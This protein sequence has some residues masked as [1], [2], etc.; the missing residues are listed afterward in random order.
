MAE[1]IREGVCRTERQATFYLEAGPVEGPLMIFVHGWP[2]MG[3][4]WRHQMIAFASLGF[5]TVAP[6]V[7]GFGR[8]AIPSDPRQL[9]VEEAVGDLLELLGHLGRDQAIWVGHDSGAAVVWGL[10]SHHPQAC[11]AVANLCVPYLPDGF[12]LEVCSALVDRG[13]YPEPEYP[14]GQWA[15]WNYNAEHLDEAAKALDSDVEAS[16][17]ICFRKG[18]SDVYAAPTLTATM[19]AP[20]GWWP[21]VEYGRHMPIDSEIFSPEEYAAF[22]TAYKMTGFAPGLNYYK[23]NDL[24]ADYAHRAVNEG[25][26]SMPVLFI[27]ASYDPSCQTT[28]SDLA[29]PMRAA[30]ANLV[31]MMVDAGHWVQ[32]EKPHAVNRCL[33]NWLST[34]VPQVWST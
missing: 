27:H 22:V 33:V 24:H 3:L 6:D 30:C 11:I 13:R 4:S 31:E 26:L 7:R 19:K 32:Q 14:Y 28:N 2:E 18:S 34:S 17:C 29:E 23:N 16:I 20:D 25:R 15:Y 12:T 9:T 8:S 10:A 21:I 5:R 1:G